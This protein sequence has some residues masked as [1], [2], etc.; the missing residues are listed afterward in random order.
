[1]KNITTIERIAMQKTAIKKTAMQKT[2]MQKT[3]IA[4][5]TAKITTTA[6]LLFLLLFTLTTNLKAQAVQE[7]S[8]S[9]F[10]AG[11]VVLDGF[12][13]DSTKSITASETTSYR[14]TRYDDETREI[15]ADAAAI[16]DTT[17]GIRP[18]V[19]SPGIEALLKA[20]CQTNANVVSVGGINYTFAVSV[21]N[22]FDAGTA[23]GDSSPVT[24]TADNP[25]TITQSSTYQQFPS[26]FDSQN[27]T[28]YQSYCYQYFYGGL[29]AERTPLFSEYEVTPD[30][31]TPPQV[32]AESDKLSGVGLQFGYRWEKWRASFTHYTGQGGD[33]EF[34][35]SLVMADYF[36]SGEFFVGAGI[37]SMQLT[38]SS[39]GSSTS[40]SA[41][42]PVLQVGYT[43]N[44]T[45]NLQLSIGVLQYSSGVSLSHSSTSATNSLQETQT[46][47]GDSA[48]IGA[49]IG[50]SAS[51]VI[52]T[53][54]YD[55]EDLRTVVTQVGERTVNIEE[56]ITPAGAG[57]TEAE[58]K[59][60][61]VISI[62][63]Q[64]SF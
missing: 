16:Y 49:S 21:L 59:A 45:K 26:G 39:A 40:A 19:L 9:G 57:N 25:Y 53:L 46:V 47:D 1:M 36:F 6:L 30:S 20:N 34:T 56:I 2:A 52:N 23:T 41:T 35:N 29:A 28:G 10:F 12:Q 3:T 15:K 38:N 17:S 7:N 55:S 60:P 22:S 61:T 14:V 8:K 18:I 33:H 32:S 24:A 64:L 48:V 27:I 63:L 62:S 4:K 43:E 11:F 13:V 54:Y 50:Y 58:L 5:T 37:A 31:G 44:L 42:S 51:S